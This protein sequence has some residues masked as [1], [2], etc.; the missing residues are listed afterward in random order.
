MCHASTRR[1]WGL[2]APLG[3]IDNFDQ[4]KAGMYRSPPAAPAGALPYL[5]G[6]A[7][8]GGSYTESGGYCVPKNERSA[9]TVYKPP[10]VQCPSG[11]FDNGGSACDVRRRDDRRRRPSRNEDPRRSRATW[12]DS[13]QRYL[14]SGEVWVLEGA[15]RLVR[16]SS[17]SV[18]A[19]S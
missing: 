11:W 7:Q 19:T 5:K 9:P 3:P 18:A 2:P 12:S 16:S 13:I 8:C 15:L 4:R 1:S 10:G 6:Q 17:Y 14:R